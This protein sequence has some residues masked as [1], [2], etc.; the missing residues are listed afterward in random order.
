MYQCIVCQFAA[1]REEDGL[2]AVLDGFLEAG[3]VLLPHGLHLVVAAH[4]VEG[5]DALDD[6]PDGHAPEQEPVLG[7]GV[8]IRIQ[9]VQDGEGRGDHAGGI[10][11]LAAIGAVTAAA[12]I[13]A[14]VAARK[15]K[16]ADW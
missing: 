10:A 3:D 12:V 15:K 2:P 1:R 4:E 13:A 11:G 7:D 9:A 14:V 6:E 16:T 8:G 5:D